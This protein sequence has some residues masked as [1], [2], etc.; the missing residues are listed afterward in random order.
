MPPSVSFQGHT[1]N[2]AGLVAKAEE[3]QIMVLAFEFDCSMQLLKAT[4]H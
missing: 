2:R 4:W 1:G 3:Q